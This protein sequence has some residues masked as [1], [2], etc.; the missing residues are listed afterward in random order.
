MIVDDS[1][2][3]RMIVTRTLK[4]AGFSGYE[5]VEATDGTD[6]LEKIQQESPDLILSDWNMPEM[7]GI[8]LLE[9]INELGK[10]IP[11]G[12]ITSE[13]SADTRKLAIDSGAQF[14]LTKPFTAESMFAALEPFMTCKS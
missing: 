10:Q 12:F 13:G 8:E 3:M 2:A 14:L 9:K 4:M 7:K 1:K 6:A 11:F 5:T